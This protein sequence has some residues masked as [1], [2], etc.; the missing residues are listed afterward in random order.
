MKEYIWVEFIRF[1]HFKTY[2]YN[3]LKTHSN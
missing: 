3:V 2:S 1:K